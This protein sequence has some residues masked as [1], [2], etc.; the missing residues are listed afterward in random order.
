MLDPR[1]VHEDG[2]RVLILLLRSARTRQK[3]GG[4]IDDGIDVVKFVG[5]RKELVPD[6]AFGL[7]KVNATRVCEL[8]EQ[9]FDDVAFVGFER[10]EAGHGQGI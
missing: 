4:V 10:F 5:S 6:L 1:C 2:K 8:S 3:V 7:A 9:S